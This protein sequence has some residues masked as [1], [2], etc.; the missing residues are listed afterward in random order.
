MPSSMYTLVAREPSFVAFVL[1]FPRVESA[2]APSPTSATH[3]PSCAL[4]YTRRTLFCISLTCFDDI[5]VRSED[6]LS[7]LPLSIP[8][9]SSPF[10]LS[11]LSSTTLSLLPTPDLIL[12]LLPS[13]SSSPR[14]VCFRND[15]PSGP[16][17]PQQQDWQQQ[18]PSELA[19]NRH[20]TNPFGTAHHCHH[21]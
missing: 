3:R 5:M 1:L 9:S 7:S 17:W 14:S 11:T 2:H 12:S 8:H 4:P 18:P 16:C 13:S 21:P 10:S 15:L 6:P 19:H 20:D